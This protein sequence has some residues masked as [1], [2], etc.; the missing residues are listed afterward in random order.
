LRNGLRSLIYIYAVAVA[1]FLPT[2]LH[3]VLILGLLFA[4]RGAVI[5][6]YLARIGRWRF[7]PWVIA[8]PFTSAIKQHIA[9]KSWGTMLPGSIPEFSE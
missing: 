4:A 6:F 9:L 5:A 2:L 3:L 7:V 8:W 1:L